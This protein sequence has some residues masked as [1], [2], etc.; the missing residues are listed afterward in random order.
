MDAELVQVDIFAK[1]YILIPINRGN[2]HWVAAAINFKQSRLEYYD[3]MSGMIG[4]SAAQKA[5]EVS[6]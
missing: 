4:R 5:A 3:S 2:A 6:F 1:D